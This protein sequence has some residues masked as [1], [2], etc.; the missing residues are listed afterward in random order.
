MLS[1]VLKYLVCLPIGWETSQSLDKPGSHQHVLKNQLVFWNFEDSW[2]TV[3]KIFLVSTAMFSRA[4]GVDPSWH[5]LQSCSADI[6]CFFLQIYWHSE[7]SDR[8]RHRSVIQVMLILFQI[9]I[10]CSVLNFWDQ[11][12]SPLLWLFSSDIHID[13]CSLVWQASFWVYGLTEHGES[14][15]FY[16][17]LFCFFPNKLD[18]WFSCEINL[19]WLLLV[20]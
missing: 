3:K 5:A 19:W 9:G 2:Y 11:G 6:S 17:Y 1:I 18:Y 20:A 8:L 14:P 4:R 15:G 13:C 10:I 16:L 7:R 12:S